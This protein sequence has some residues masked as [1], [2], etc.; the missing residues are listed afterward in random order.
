VTTATPAQTSS[1][2]SRVQELA[3]EI[4]QGLCRVLEMDGR[5][6]AAAVLGSI[7]G[8]HPSMRSRLLRALTTES[9]PVC[10]YHMPGPDGLR[11]VLK[12]AR[13]AKADPDAIQACEVAIAR[14][15]RFLDQERIS[16]Q[17]LRVMLGGYLPEVASTLLRESTR[18][19]YTAMCNIQGYHAQATLGTWIIIPGTT[20]DRCTTVVVG[21]FTGLRRLRKDPWTFAFARRVAGFDA[22]GVPMSTTLDGVPTK[23]LDQ[24]AF[25]EPF[26]SKPLPNFDEFTSDGWRRFVLQQSDVGI[27]SACTFFFCEVFPD[28]EP[29]FASD[30]ESDV[31][32]TMVVSTPSRRMLIDH[33]MHNDIWTGATPELEC[34]RTIPHGPVRRGDRDRR[35]HDRID[36]RIGVDRLAPG[37]DAIENAA[38]GT[39]RQILA[40]VFERLGL[41]FSDFHGFRCDIEHPLYASQIALRFDLPP[42]P[43]T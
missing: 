12:A 13:L 2:F 9:G 7:P 26:C 40:H 32:Q 22:H 39:Y 37:L 28:S 16:R 14:F 34:Y 17:T 5:R 30:G 24:P 31:F 15:E 8:V 10:L 4:R 35:S 18:G 43:G 19:A 1:F 29:R 25:L 41:E 23:D 6:T 20:P 42:R 36:L 11:R 38:I 33:I 3:T 27:R 21:G